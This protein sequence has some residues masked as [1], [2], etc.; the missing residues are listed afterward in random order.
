MGHSGHWLALGLI[1]LGIPQCRYGE[2]VVILRTPPT[3]FSKCHQSRQC[4]YPNLH[5]CTRFSTRSLHRFLSFGLGVCRIIGMCRVWG[6]CKTLF[7]D[8]LL[9]WT[10]KIILLRACFKTRNSKYYIPLTYHNPNMK[11][12]FIMPFLPLKPK[13]PISPQKYHRR[14]PAIPCSFSMVWRAMVFSKLGIVD[15]NGNGI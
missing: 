14:S 6:L 12:S 15:K 1:I 5:L 7:L 4:I 13:T 3:S 11:N 2:A 10:A 8:M 9:P